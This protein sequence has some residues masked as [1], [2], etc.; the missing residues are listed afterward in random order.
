MLASDDVEVLSLICIKDFHSISLDSVD[1]SFIGRI[2][3]FVD[4]DYKISSIYVWALRV[5]FGSYYHN[6]HIIDS[7]WESNI[8]T[9]T[10]ISVSN[11]MTALEIAIQRFEGLK[12]ENIIHFNELNPLIDLIHSLNITLNIMTSLCNMSNFSTQSNFYKDFIE[13]IIKQDD[14]NDR[15]K[16]L[17][18]EY[19]GETL[20]PLI[21]RPFSCTGDDES[22]N[23]K[24]IMTQDCIYF[25]SDN[26]IKITDTDITSTIP[27]YGNDTKVILR[28]MFL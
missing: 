6:A 20:I 8:P 19:I 26:Y 24:T 11:E 27:Y 22:I 17:L 13:N 18:D 23:M 2:P 14:I 15:A 21:S 9:S 5:S 12:Q 28:Q 1:E 16:V 7:L 10:A 25:G 4:L 3:I